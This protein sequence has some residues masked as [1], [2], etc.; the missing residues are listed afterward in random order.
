M[1][2]LFNT[3]AYV[4]VEELTVS[5]M[6]SPPFHCHN[7]TSCTCTYLPLLS[8]FPSELTC[9][10][11]PAVSAPRDT[12][13]VSAI[14]DLLCADENAYTVIVEKNALPFCPYCYREPLLLLALRCCWYCFL[15]KTGWEAFA[16]LPSA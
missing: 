12:A 9:F 16:L 2:F 1:S 10:S 14:T 8:P 6:S 3:V 15:L 4:T 5:I 11:C 13:T 7:G